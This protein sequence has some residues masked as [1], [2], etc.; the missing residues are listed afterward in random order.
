MQSRVTKQRNRDA[1]TEAANTSPAVSPADGTPMSSEEQS[2]LDREANFVDAADKV[3]AKMRTD[4]ETVTKE[5]GDTLHSRE[6]KAFGT[7]E[8]GGI[9][10]QAQSLASQNEKK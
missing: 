9:A 7:T 1:T 5:D 4:P 8:K 6:T 2:K 3:G 10:S